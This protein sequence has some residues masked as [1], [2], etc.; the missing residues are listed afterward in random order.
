[1]GLLYGRTG[2][3]TAKAGGFRPGQCLSA[4]GF[5]AQFALLNGC[6]PGADG[7]APAVRRGPLAL[8]RCM[9]FRSIDRISSTRT[10]F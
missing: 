4:A 7:G 2:R 9:Y 8:R 6:A 5:V 10:E 3:L 1:M